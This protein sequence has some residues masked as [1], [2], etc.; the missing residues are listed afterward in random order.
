MR[1]SRWAVAVSRFFLITDDHNDSVQVDDLSFAEVDRK[2]SASYGCGYLRINLI[3]SD[4]QQGIAGLDDIPFAHKPAADCYIFDTL[5]HL[6][7]SDFCC[8]GVTPKASSCAT[9]F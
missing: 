8:H 1:H 6:R 3:S 4:R 2:N 7:Q 9:D 5:A